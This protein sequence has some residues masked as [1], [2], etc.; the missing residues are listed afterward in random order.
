MINGSEIQCPSGTYWMSKMNMNVTSQVTPNLVYF[1]RT[2]LGTSS[3]SLELIT[4]QTVIA[5]GDILFVQIS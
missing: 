3:K 4:Q 5:A 2:K 1:A